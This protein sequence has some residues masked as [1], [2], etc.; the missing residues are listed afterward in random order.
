MTSVT[1]K[2]LRAPNSDF[3]QLVD[4]LTADEKASILSA[5][6]SAPSP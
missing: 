2:Q 6:T 4:V 1:P 5:M 3:Y